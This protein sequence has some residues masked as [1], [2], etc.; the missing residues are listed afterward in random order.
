MGFVGFGDHRSITLL[1]P[2]AERLFRLPG[3]LSL[4]LIAK[5]QLVHQ[6]WLCTK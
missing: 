5:N 6:I 2:V 1:H 3:I 4:V